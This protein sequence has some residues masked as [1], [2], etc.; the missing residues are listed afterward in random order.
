MRHGRG[1]GRRSFAHLSC[2]SPTSSKHQYME[3]GRKPAKCPKDSFALLSVSRERGLPR[4]PWS[5]HSVHQPRNARKRTLVRHGRGCGK[6][7]FAHLNRKSPTSSKHQYMED[8]RK[9]AKCPEDSFALLSVPRERGLPR[10]P[11]SN[12]DTHLHLRRSTTECAEAHPCAARKWLGKRRLLNISRDRL[13]CRVDYKTR[14]RI[15]T[16]GYAQKFT[17]SPSLNSVALR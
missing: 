5:K 17:R 9:P 3:D 1:W 16:L 14:R 2:K 8:G 12:N 13:A 11:W 15:S 7:G 4:F 6:G 10:F